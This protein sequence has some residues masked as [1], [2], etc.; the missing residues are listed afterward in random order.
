MRVS[1]PKQRVSEM[2][3]RWSLFLPT[4][5]ETLSANFGQDVYMVGEDQRAVWPL[6]AKMI[7]KKQLR[8]TKHFHVLPAKKL[9][10]QAM[11]AMP[12]MFLLGLGVKARTEHDPFEFV[13]PTPRQNE[14]ILAYRHVVADSADIQVDK[15]R[16]PVLEATRKLAREWVDGAR[17]GALIPLQPV[18]FDDSMRDGVKSEIM[19]RNSAVASAM[20]LNA[21]IEFDSRQYEKGIQDALLGMEVSNV[22]KYSDYSTVMQ[23]AIYDRRGLRLIDEAL[24]RVSPQTRLAVRKDLALV[25]PDADRFQAIQE[26]ERIV[27]LDYINRMS[28]ESTPIEAIDPAD[29]GKFEAAGHLHGRLLASARDDTLPASKEAQRMA[30]EGEAEV[31]RMYKHTLNLTNP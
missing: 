27:F 18:S 5:R 10:Y 20:L 28:P 2:M 23:G 7:V 11:V 6:H 22:I 17:S 4:K 14:A 3:G 25:R 24:T 12:A 26:V 1:A 29:A 8:A 15:Y 16:I 9:V 19:N 21:S 13:Q 31:V 30:Q